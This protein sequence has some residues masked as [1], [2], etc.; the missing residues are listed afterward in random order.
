MEKHIFIF[1][2]AFMLLCNTGVKSQICRADTIYDMEE[3]TQKQISEAVDWVYDNFKDFDREC[4]LIGASGDSNGHYQT[5][6]SNKSSDEVNDKVKWLFRKDL[7]FIPDTMSIQ[8]VATLGN[9]RDENLAL[10][11][12]A[13][14]KNDYPDLRLFRVCSIYPFTR[15]YGGEMK[16]TENKEPV[17]NYE[18]YDVE[19]FSSSLAKTIAGYYNFDYDNISA[20]SSGGDIGYGGVINREKI[21][22]EAQKMSFLA[23]VFM[24]C[25]AGFFSIFEEGNR[26]SIWKRR[27]PSST[28]K[29]CIDILKEFGCENIEEQTGNKGK[30]YEFIAFDASNKIR[31][32]IFLVYDLFCKMAVTL[33]N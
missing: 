6:T 23:G 8:R 7:K 30:F 18:T 24:H 9:W 33:V 15:Y 14:F 16:T 3:W 26:V 20:V 1:A 13:L 2:I 31:N 10:F 29:E 5:F 25:P 12:T 11:M 27:L 21:V 32:F 28:A 4:F 17:C 19:L 22:T